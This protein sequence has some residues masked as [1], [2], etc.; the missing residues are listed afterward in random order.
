MIKNYLKIALRSLI[1][2][3]GYSLINITGL[4]ISLAVT[5]LMLLWVH[6]EWSIDKFHVNGDNIYRV[7]R[8]IPLEGNT[9]D[10]YNGIPYQVLSTAQKELPGVE[11][12][13]P[14]GRS[15]EETLQ[16]E[17]ITFREKGTFGTSAY[18]EL[19]SYPVLLGDISELDEKID[20]LAISKSVAK[21][22][23][24]NVWESSTIGKTIHIH[25]LGDFSIVAIY[26]DF[27]QSSSIQHDFVYNFEKHLK[28][29][30]WMLE[31]GNAGMQGAI[32]LAPNTEPLAVAQK[33][34]K[35]FQGHQ[36]KD[37]KE[38]IILQKYA[39][40]YLY[41]NFDEQAKVSGGR[42]E[43]V[44]TFGIAALLLLLISCINFVNLATARASKRAKEVGVRKT[45]GADKK[46]LI[47][48]FMVEAGVITSISI[49]LAYF[50]AEM[51]IPQVRLI[52]DKMLAFDL[53]NPVFWAG[54]G[55]IFL[56]TTLLSGAYPAFVLSSFRPVNA[57]KGKATSNPSSG[58]IS[59]RKSLVV[60]Q[61]VL[62]LLLI[63]GALVVRQQVNFIKNKNLGIAKNNLLVIHQDDKLTAQYDV[64][65]NE[66]LNQKGIDDATLAGPSPLNI[67]SSTSGV[68]WPEKRPD[69]ENIE[70]AMI[71]TSSN[72]VDVFDVPLV[73][74]R[75]YREG[76]IYD[77]TS[78]VFN[79]T[80]INIMGLTDPVGQ[81]IRWWGK[82]RQIIGVVKDFHNRS[83]YE[84]IQ[85]TG[86]MLDS[87]DAGYLFVKAKEG[88]MKDAIASVE[89]TFNKVLP[90]VP[91]HFDFL[92]E[93]YQEQYKNEELTGTLADFFAIFSIL[94]SCLGLFGLATFFAEQKEKE[95]GIRKVLGATV[96]N[97][98][99]LLSRQFLMLVGIGL[100]IGIPVSGYLLSG[101]L[102]NFAYKVDLQFWMFALPVAIAI[103]IATLTVGF[104]A[105]RAAIANPIESLRSE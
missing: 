37:R 58:S 100:L 36:D 48:Q 17:D 62:A 24:G 51:L 87:E 1:N 89:S 39:D 90:D 41:G 53:S 67:Q 23:F 55:G 81:S 65:Y 63:V 88:E 77:T 4:S 12:F 82:Q 73:Q 15:F 9:L 34:E 79:E 45:I 92:D 72:F 71:W 84:E 56:F 60:V 44:R 54:I 75:Y 13:V 52:T 61:F 101:W 3:K 91:L 38:G 27:P 85:P 11:K 103:F 74:G 30:A 18:F 104:Q 26:E 35:L 105:L 98:I 80:A 19:F 83:L 78:I 69:Q 46:S 93:Q 14:L 20:A 5:M 22:V 86:F 50:M 64:L 6:D 57:L 76:S 10:V 16:Y 31:W 96:F 102:S 95:I 59:L 8:T 99:Q 66:L 70:F 97:L 47:A 28:N 68:G 33:I 2:H 43:Y 42:I 29:N 40:H 25:N 49:G 7:K 94:L 32:M 21:K